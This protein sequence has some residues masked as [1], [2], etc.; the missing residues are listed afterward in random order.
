MKKQTSALQ[1]I[2]RWLKKSDV[3]Q[4]VISNGGV[5]RQ[6]AISPEERRDRLINPAKY[7]GK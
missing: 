3:S 5:Q 6:L 2:I 1:T 4:R 7:L